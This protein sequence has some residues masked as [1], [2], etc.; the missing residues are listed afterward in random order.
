MKVEVEKLGECKQRLKIEVPRE[1]VDRQFEAAYKELGRKSRVDGFRPGKVPLPILRRRFQKVAAAEALKK[2]V[3]VSYPEAMKGKNILPL[4]DPDIEIG[5]ALPE[6]EK[7]FSFQVTVET[8]PE[9]E[10]K[11]Y[12]GLSLERERIEISDEE[13]ETVLEMKREENADFLPVEG[14]PVKED[15]WVVVDFKSFLDGNPFQSAEGH[16][17][18]LSSGVFPREVEER[19]IGKLPEA[20]EE[21]EVEAPLSGEKSSAKLLYQ[22][23]LKGIKERRLLIVDDEFARDLGEF[24]S[25]AELRED[26]RKKLEIRAREEEEGKLRGGIVDILV[27]RN[28]VEVP[29]RLVEE[30]I[31]HLMLISRAELG[32][33]DEEK[34]K[35]ELREKLR[36]PAIKQ[37][38]ASLILEEIARRE[39]IAATE[40]EIKKEA[41]GN[42]IPLTKERREDLA[43]RIKRRKTLD[44][45]ISQAEVKEKEKPLVLTPDQVRMLMPR[46]KKFREPGGG[47]I[48]VP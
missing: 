8:W 29:P 40:E 19:L 24:N 47:R 39:N 46:E 1:E 18:R 6:E 2:I 34:G 43:H 36:P 26:I 25:L 10:V 37:V 4:S 28:E 16:L 9:V 3:A 30:Q 14:R 22:V 20:D 41:E 21:Q 15:D 11:S 48:I 27:E 31:N 33:A 17:F 44:F 7:P 45:L 38:K 23:K 5:E 32:S 35:S 42:K 13:V 12:K